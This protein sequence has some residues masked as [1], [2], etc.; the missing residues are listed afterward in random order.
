MRST[1]LMSYGVSASPK[2]RI[3]AIQF[4]VTSVL[5]VAVG[6]T[7][8]S[9][10][11]IGTGVAFASASGSLRRELASWSIPPTKGHPSP[12]ESMANESSERR[13]LTAQWAHHR[14]R[15]RRGGG[16]GVYPIY[17][18]PP[19]HPLHR[20]QKVPSASLQ[21]PKHRGVSNCIVG[22]QMTCRHSRR[23]DK[24]NKSYPP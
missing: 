8:A 16:T 24:L 18:Q 10:T 5:L 19:K 22:S 12:T 7:S 21:L 23:V 13:S 3:I 1:L 20:P 4:L 15:H 17:L 2:R 11:L 6:C 9:Y 14:Y